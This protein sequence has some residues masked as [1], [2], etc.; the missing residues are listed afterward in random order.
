[1]VLAGLI[2]LIGVGVWVLVAVLGGKTPFGNGGGGGRYTGGTKV[3]AALGR[4]VVRVRVGQTSGPG[5]FI[6]E[7]GYILTSLTLVPAWLGADD[8]QEAPITVEYPARVGG[9]WTTRTASLRG[10]VHRDTE[11]N[12][13]V[14]KVPLP[15]GVSVSKPAFADSPGV[16]AGEHWG[17]IRLRSGTQTAD[18]PEAVPQHADDQIKPTSFGE[19]F[20]GTNVKYDESLDGAP[21]FNSRGEVFAIA[22]SPPGRSTSVMHLCWL[23]P[24]LIS[25][26]IGQGGG[27]GSP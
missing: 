4:P 7:D 12:V 5:F 8:T 22:T 15:A 9:A 14:L 23:S 27:G 17:L 18:E 16:A 6:S 2:V 21:A 13:A 26:L 3:P 20:A 25:R 24:P 1:V 10:A 19:V 11:L